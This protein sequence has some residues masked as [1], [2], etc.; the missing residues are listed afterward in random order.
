[1]KY[2][3]YCLITH[4][5]R[6]GPTP[7]IDR[8]ERHAHSWREPTLRLERKEKIFLGSS[9]IYGCSRETGRSSLVV[10]GRHWVWPCRSEELSGVAIGVVKVLSS[11]GK[12]KL[13]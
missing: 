4:T 12:S 5:H 13:A 9:W 11:V 1:M 8:Y 10:I 2:L 7:E 3:F 6:G